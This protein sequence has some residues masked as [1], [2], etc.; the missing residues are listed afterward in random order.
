MLRGACCII[1]PPIMYVCMYVIEECFVRC[2]WTLPHPWALPP[3]TNYCSISFETI[4]ST[5]AR[6]TAGEQ[7][8]EMLEWRSQRSHTMSSH[9]PTQL[10]L[11]CSLART[12]RTRNQT[13]TDFPIG[14]FLRRL[15]PLNLRYIYIYIYICFPLSRPPTPKLPIQL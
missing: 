9:T 11:A 6:P 4:S 10:R 14:G 1:M 12:S 3:K 7:E 2:S 8:K 5:K 13:G 15:I